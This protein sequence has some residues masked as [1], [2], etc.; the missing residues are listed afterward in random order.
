MAK[1]PTFGE[2]RRRLRDEGWMPRRQ[3][4]SH[5]HWYHNETGRGPV[6]LAGKDS[7]RPAPGTWNSIQ[8]QAGW[9]L[10]EPAGRQM[11]P[12]GILHQIAL[13]PGW[14]AVFTGG[15]T[16]T[17]IRVIVESVIENGQLL[18]FSAYAPEWPGCVAAAETREETVA[19]MR[20]ALAGHISSIIGHQLEPQDLLLTITDAEQ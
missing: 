10:R 11:P 9:R 6:T 2:I 18:N 7:Q 14:R 12:P 13:S 3:N 20:D 5:E 15:E 4:G 1:V 19:L 16:V 8:E 17:P